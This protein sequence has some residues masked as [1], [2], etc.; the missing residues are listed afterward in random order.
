LLHIH[1]KGDRDTELPLIKEAKRQ[2]NLEVKVVPV[3]ATPGFDRV[4]AIGESPEFICDHALV[5]DVNNVE[6]LKAALHWCITGEPDN[7]VTTMEKWLSKILGGKV[8]RKNEVN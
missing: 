2:L 1:T 8:E 7:R 4:L 6:S 5:K 3:V